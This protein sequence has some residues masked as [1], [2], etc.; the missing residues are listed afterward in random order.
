DL[1]LPDRN[2]PVH[3]TNRRVLP[4]H[5]LRGAGADVGPDPGQVL[6]YIYRQG[7]ILRKPDKAYRSGSFEILLLSRRIKQN[8]PCR[9]AGRRQ[10]QPSNF[11]H[12]SDLRVT[13]TARP[14]EPT[15]TTG[16]SGEACVAV[17][18]GQGVRTVI[19]DFTFVVV[20]AE[21]AAVFTGIA[22]GTGVS[23]AVSSVV[24]AVA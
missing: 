19:A 22:V 21:A 1:R 14:I 24:V 18:V 23:T 20:F 17:S 7:S 5:I 9:D 11:D 15:I 10:S 4:G 3:E 13:N 16:S 6:C 2:K 8:I 12:F